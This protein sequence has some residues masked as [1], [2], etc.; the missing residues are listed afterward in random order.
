MDVICERIIKQVSDDIQQRVD[1]ILS[2]I[3]VVAN[4]T[5]IFFLSVATENIENIIETVQ[6]CAT[7]IDLQSQLM[8]YKQT[9]KKHWKVWQTMQNALL[10]FY[11]ALITNL[12]IRKIGLLKS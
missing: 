3:I 9:I 8:A 4:I 12:T 11:G 7:T 5:P 10:S 2:T 1:A 6:V